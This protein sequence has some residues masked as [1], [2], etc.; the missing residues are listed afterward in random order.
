MRKPK[1]PTLSVD[2]I[3]TPLDPP[4]G[5]KEE[6]KD[7]RRERNRGRRVGIGKGNNRNHTSRDFATVHPQASAAATLNAD[8][9]RAPP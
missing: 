3:G 7:G 5:R 1:N 6:R 9:S 8:A 4:K 2:D